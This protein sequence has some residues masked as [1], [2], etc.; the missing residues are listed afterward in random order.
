MAISEK[1]NALYKRKAIRAID[2]QFSQFIGEQLGDVESPMV[3]WAALVSFELGKGNVCIDLSALDSARL[4]DLMPLESAEL[5]ILMTPENALAL[6]ST[7]PVVGDG[8]VPKPMVLSGSRLY[9]HRYWAAERLVT[10][11]ITARAK[12]L[13]LPMTLRGVL[14]DLFLPDMALLRRF[15]NTWED[16][17]K[18]EKLVDFF[19]I[20][21]LTQ[22]D[23]DVLKTALDA[24]ATDAQVLSLVPDSARLNWQKVAA[25]VALSYRFAVISGG[26]GTGKTTTVAKLLAAIVSSSDNPN[27]PEIKLVAPTGKAANRL[28]ESIGK[29]VA[30]LPVSNEVR[31]KIP[32]QASTI[33]RLLGAIP[34]RVEFRHHAGNR[35]HLDVLVVDEASMVD[36]P[37]MARLLAAL[38]QHARV[39]L[40]GDRDQLA[41]VEAGAVLGD[42]CL[43]AG[44]GF[45]AERAK[46]LASLTGFCMPQEASVPVVSDGVCLLRKSYRFHAKSGVGQLAY[47]INAG[48]TRWVERVLQR[49]FSDI[50]LH[51]LDGDVYGEAIAMVVNGYRGYLSALSEGADNRTLLKHFSDIRLLCALSDGPFGVKGLNTAIEKALTK[52]ELIAPGEEIFYPGRPIMVTQNDHG[53][54]LYNG[55]IGIVVKQEEGLRVVFEMADGSVKAF[56]PSR[57][58]EHQTAYAMTIHKSQGSEFSHTILMLPPTPTPVMT[59]EL[60]YTG[61]TRAK[62]RLDVYATRTSLAR[63]VKRKTQR[64][65]GLADALHVR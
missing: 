36:L 24:Q 57:L 35:L 3:G 45:S 46:T 63:A 4:F 26:P 39:I 38:P 56:L 11:E 33:H 60:V 6:V 9:L 29:A 65:S 16:S 27:G 42:I 10:N 13:P 1:L 40:L 5:A 34:N 19:D 7:S 2:R 25:A 18:A 8:S 20:T 62:D 32:T 14:D 49:G 12:E 44:S 54:G 41:S 17:E 48:E 30:A 15:Y 51:D 43:H 47:A 31:D 55:D 59:R 61:V 64:F 53:L 37:M 21:D 52:V 58:P 50:A 28:T 23:V 22:V